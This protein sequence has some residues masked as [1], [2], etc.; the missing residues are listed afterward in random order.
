MFPWIAM[1]ESVWIRVAGRC[2]IE[3]DCWVY[4]KT[5]AAGYPNNVGIDGRFTHAHRALLLVAR[6]P[7][8]SWK[9]AGHLCENRACCNP[10]HLEWQTRSENLKGRRQHGRKRDPW[11][12]KCRENPKVEGQGYCRPCFNAYYRERRKAVSP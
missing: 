8:H 9:D 11:C 12:P 5:T 10:E 4:P 3:G 6:P 2:T 1:A 7:A